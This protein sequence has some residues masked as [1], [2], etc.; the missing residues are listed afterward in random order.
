MYFLCI[1]YKIT[2]SIKMIVYVSAWLG[3]TTQLLNHTNAAVE[4]FCRCN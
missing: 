2:I 4:V 3:Y 1:L